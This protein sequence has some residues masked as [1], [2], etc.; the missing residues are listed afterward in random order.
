MKVIIT[1]RSFAQADAEP[2]NMLQ[3]EGFDL[4][5]VTDMRELPQRIGEADGI[6]AGLEAYGKELFSIAPRLKIISRYGVGCDAIDLAA[7]KD[8]GVVVTVT[9]GANSD[10]VADLAVTLLL[11]AA[12][13]V[14]RMDASIRAGK[15]ER[16]LGVE[17]WR[18]VIGVIGTGR[19]GKGVI[20]RLRGF[21]MQVLMFDIYQDNAFAR[22]HNARYV[23]LDVLYRE[24]DFIT[25]HSPL[26]EE[27]R[28]MIG[29]NEFAK[30][31]KTAVI[32]NTA[33]GGIIDEAALA[34]ALAAGSIG[35]AALDAT[36][37]EP[38]YG[39]PLCAL[40]NCILTP[41][42]G[43]ATYEASLNMGRMSARNVIDYF[44]TGTCANAV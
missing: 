34:A 10:S 6:I 16:P 24:S 11:S 41:H 40:P 42:A 15:Q 30:M 17:M 29:K 26:T 32:V 33:R 31:K 14:P 22:E 8:A 28:S 21:Q 12:R 7:A 2:L 3:N 35:A 1:A 43:A 27:T 44:R 13:Q 37:T 23:P 18:K 38:P 20:E 19:I 36:I 9:P 4:E 25:I 5:R 39:S